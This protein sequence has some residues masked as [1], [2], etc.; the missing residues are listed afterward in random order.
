M[1]Q[2]AKPIQVRNGQNYV[3]LAGVCFLDYASFI[4]H[5][6]VHVIVPL[7]ASQ[8]AA[9]VAT[10]ASIFVIAHDRTSFRTACST[11]GA[12]VHLTNIRAKSKE[13]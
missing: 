5:A 3:I 7:Y 12:S 2:T 9:T 6:N 11:Y 4:R 10:V 8:P 13:R 1:P